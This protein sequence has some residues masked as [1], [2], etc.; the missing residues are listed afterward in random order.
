MNGDTLNRPRTPDGN[1]LAD[2][3]VREDQ[4]D[5]L[6]IGS[7]IELLPVSGSDRIEAKM[8]VTY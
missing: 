5:G 8:T 7:P 4:L 6:R 3:P 1:S 2:A